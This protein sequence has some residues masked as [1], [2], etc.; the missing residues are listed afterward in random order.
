VRAPGDLGD[1][2]ENVGFSVHGAKRPLRTQQLERPPHD[3]RWIDGDEGVF[4]RPCVVEE[5]ANDPIH[6]LELLCH[7]FGDFPIGAPAPQ[8]LDVRAD[9]T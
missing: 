8:H 9:R 5:A 7:P 4:L 6:P 1:V 2:R 3:A